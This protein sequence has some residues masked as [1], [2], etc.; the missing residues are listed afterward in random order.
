M[1]PRWRGCTAA[2]SA[3]VRS[4]ERVCAAA[5]MQAAEAGVGLVWSVENRS[6]SVLDRSVV[7]D[8]W[9]VLVGPCGSLGVSSSAVLYSL[10][11]FGVHKRPA[12]GLLLQCM[13]NV[14]LGCMNRC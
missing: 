1:G 3:R 6:T 2:R 11:C 9:A 5:T 12:H 13:Q 7:T 14:V 8:W 4:D 10:G